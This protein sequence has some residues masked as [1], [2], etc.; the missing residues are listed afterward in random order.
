MFDGWGLAPPSHGNAITLAKTP[1]MNSYYEKYPHGELIAA[2]ESV[3]LPAGEVGNSEVGHLT[4]GVGRVIY[5]SLK[6][7]NISIDNKEFFSN[8]SLAS[9]INHAV[10]NGS[11]LHVMGLIGSGN[12]HSN[13]DHLFAIM[14]YCKKVNFDRLYLHLFTDGRDAPPDDGFNVIGRIE[15]KI[16]SLKVGQIASITGRYYAMDRDGRWERIKRTYDLL[17]SGIGNTAVSA[18]EAMRASY[19][20]GKTDE[21]VEPVLITPGGN[22]P[23]LIASNDALIYFNF[24]V[25]RARELT[26]AF[27]LPNFEKINLEDYGFET[28]KDYVASE[29]GVTTFVRTNMPTN[30]FVTTMTEYQKGLP[31][32]AVLFPPQ[33]KFPDSIVEVISKHNLKQFH[34]AE[35]EKERMVTYYF[36]GM[37]AE[38]FPGED[39][40]IIPSPN[41]PT[42]DRKPEMSAYKLVREFK[43]AINKNI[44]SFVVMNFAN[45]DM[46]AHSG[47]L[48]AT[49]KA[50]E[51]VD[52]CISEIV[53]KTLSVDGTVMISADHGNAEELLSFEYQSF[54][55]TTE[56]GDPNTDHSFNPVP[57][58]V[59]NNS[60][61]NRSDLILSGTLADIA[62]T[63]LGMMDIDKPAV[64]TGHCLFKKAAASKKPVQ[65]QRNTA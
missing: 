35:S 59:I 46:V 29:D 33:D 6:R 9:T 60:Y 25:D 38:S 41:V 31:V 15:S 30:I 39:V 57:I 23:P 43:K 28:K 12:V 55:Y 62:P 52:H 64:M 44:Y 42:Y 11:N 47:N 56:Q 21:F 8:K 17:V 58:L 49:I 45:P 34:L 3:G 13:T 32:S 10:K 61:E 22:T 27:T 2:G 20:A 50:I 54:F 48:Q 19:A 5:Q 4:A 24:R 63:I 40:V 14:E 53:K 16:N 65:P 37:N 26:M 7:I 1:N 51:V 18:T 36:G